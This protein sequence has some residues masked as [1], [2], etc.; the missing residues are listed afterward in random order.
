MARGLLPSLALLALVAPTLAAPAAAD[1]GDVTDCHLDAFCTADASAAFA[2]EQADDTQTMMAAAIESWIAA[3]DP[4][5]AAALP[6]DGNGLL[7]AGEGTATVTVNGRTA[8]C[9]GPS[10]AML[11][12]SHKAFGMEPSMTFVDGGATQ[13]GGFLL[14]CTMGQ[15]VQPIQT[16]LQPGSQFPDGPWHAIKTAAGF[17]WDLQVSGPQEGG[18]VVTYTYHSADGLSGATFSG[19]L[20]VYR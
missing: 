17:V 13:E 16:D 14:P 12:A 6:D 19:V 5:T 20:A 18:R 7:L 9:I 8:A 1:L 2:E 4:I 11:E 15:K 10:T 3:F